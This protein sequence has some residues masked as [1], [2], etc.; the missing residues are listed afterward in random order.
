MCGYF[1]GKVWGA[2]ITDFNSISVYQLAERVVRGKVFVN[3]SQK[4]GTNVSS[5]IGCK[6]G[7]EPSYDS[8]SGPLLFLTGV[9]GGFIFQL[10]VVPTFVQ[11]FLIEGG[12]TPEHFFI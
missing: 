9:Q 1:H 11:G 4:L 3:E 7:I 2:H 10:V 6:W 8:F 5:N 12:G